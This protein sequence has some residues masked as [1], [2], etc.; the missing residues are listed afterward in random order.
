MRFFDEVEK[1]DDVADYDTDKTCDSQ[2]THKSEGLTHDR[3][4]RKG[5][6]H[7]VRD[8]REHKER[9]DGIAEL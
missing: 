8:G 3:E 2:E 9:L 6:R 1:N 4:S 7:S 5:S